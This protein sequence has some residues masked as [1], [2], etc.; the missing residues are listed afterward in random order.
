MSEDFQLTNIKIAKMEEKLD[1]IL[2]K[3]NENK[4][5]HVEIMNKVEAY[6]DSSEIKF[7]RKSIEIEVINLASKMEQRNYDWLKYAVIT[8]IGFLFTFLAEHFFK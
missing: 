1:H 4:D 8:A 7:A 5:E 6:I 3:L 2:E